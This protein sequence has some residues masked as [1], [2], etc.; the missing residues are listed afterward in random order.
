MVEFLIGEKVQW[1]VGN[2]VCR[3]L[4][5]EDNLEDTVGVICFEISEKKA[6]RKVDV[7]RNLLLKIE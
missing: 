2:L 4:V 1:T 7:M 3:G 5:F 6:N